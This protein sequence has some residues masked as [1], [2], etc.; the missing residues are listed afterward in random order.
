MTLR[1]TRHLLFHHHQEAPKRSNRINNMSFSDVG[2]G[3]PKRPNRTQLSTQPTIPESEES[4]SDGL[5]QLSDGILQYQACQRESKG[6][7]GFNVFLHIFFFLVFIEKSWNFRANRW[8]S[9]NK[10]R[11]TRAGTT[12]SLSLFFIQESCHRYS[13]LIFSL[14]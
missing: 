9:R 14:S 11:W 2:K 4:L 5:R 1:T 10:V 13:I 3:G 6:L 12:V 7:F 8:S